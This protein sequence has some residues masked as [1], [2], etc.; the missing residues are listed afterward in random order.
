[1]RSKER[2]C[3]VSPPFYVR[4]LTLPE[5][6]RQFFALA[7]EVFSAPPS[8][9]NAERWR[10]RTL[11]DPDIRS[12]HVRGVF[13]DGRFVGGYLLSERLLRMG[14]ARIPIT[15]VSAVFTHPEY[16]NRGVA[17][18]LMRDAISFA[19]SH[20]SAV[21]LL[22]G[23]PK[24]YHRFGYTD[25]FDLSSQLVDRGAVLAQ[26]PGAHAVRVVTLDDAE[27]ILA[28]YDRHY[29]PYTGSF[30]RSIE[31]Q[32]YQLRYHASRKHMVVTCDLEGAIEGYLMLP[33]ASH[34][35]VALEC[36]AENWEA[37]LSLLRYHALLYEGHKDI[38]QSLR[39]RLP[40]SSPMVEWMIQRLEVPDTSQWD[41]A[42]EGWSVLSQTYHHR[43]AGCMA[44]LVHFP[45]LLE[46]ML[47]EMRVRW[48]N[49]LAHWEGEITLAV[50]QEAA[51]LRI[52]RA[53]R[54]SRRSSSGPADAA[55][56]DAT[57][58]R[59]S[60][61]LRDSARSFSGALPRGPGRPG[62]SVSNWSRMD[63]RV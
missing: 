23:I 44:R 56:S 57:S 31:Q 5:E 51:T 63:S 9:E 53:D 19:A 1:M 54:L 50:G 16:R 20:R 52:T 62:T 17:T 46:P 26:E 39:Y 18:A 48:Q 8:Q 28:L 12:E 15:R 42:H 34:P 7:D 40:P 10:Q 2:G 14:V 6:Y 25:A 3:L 41:T 59:I 33:S 49:T 29:G 32:R 4:A 21:L 37:L 45:S 47:P 58:L 11:A 38:P 55:A 30:V 22:D 61:D 24:F 60:L 35:D 13:R 43:Y 27:D 36:A